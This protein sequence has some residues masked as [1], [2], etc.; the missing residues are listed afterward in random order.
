MANLRQICGKSTANLRQICEKS[1]ANL[2]QICG[3]TCG[4]SAAKLEA[5]LV[6]KLAANL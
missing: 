6:P 3:I 4:K 5:N 2:R 1:A